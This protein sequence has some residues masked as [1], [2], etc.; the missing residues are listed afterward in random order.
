MLINVR[1]HDD[2]QALEFINDVLRDL[3][4]EEVEKTHYS[5]KDLQINPEVRSSH[6][7]EGSKFI[8]IENYLILTI[9]VGDL[10]IKTQEII[11]K[12]KNKLH[13]L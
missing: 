6:L 3:G 2:K 9:T 12:H 8:T 7:S 5:D 11:Q 10:D 13:R 1:V 4:K